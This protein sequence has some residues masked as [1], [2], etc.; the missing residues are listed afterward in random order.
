MRTTPNR[1][2]AVFVIDDIQTIFNAVVE[3]PIEVPFNSTSA[4]L[5]YDDI[6]SL[7]S[8]RHYSGRIGPE[9]FEL[10]LHNG[11]TIKGE[12]NAPGLESENTVDG[13]GVWEQA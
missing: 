12:L 7:T 2:T 5:T 6:S 13:A 4:T 1:V 9:K 3:P 11:P 8:T 10:T